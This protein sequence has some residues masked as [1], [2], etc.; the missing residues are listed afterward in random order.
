MDGSDVRRACT[1]ARTAL[2]TGAGVH[3]PIERGEPVEHVTWMLAKIPDLYEA[4]R[5]EKAMRWLGFVQGFIWACDFAGIDEM[6]SWNR[7]QEAEKV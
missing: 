3:L 2:F 4:G 5:I 7:P 1:A 6:K